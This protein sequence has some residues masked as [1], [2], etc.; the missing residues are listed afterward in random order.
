MSNWIGVWSSVQDNKRKFYVG[1]HPQ[2]AALVGKFEKLYDP[3]T[4]TT[5]DHYS[6][7]PIHHQPQPDG[8]WLYFRTP[9]K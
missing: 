3:N 9:V 7:W 4:G 1:R 6:Y 8:K 5:S 2:N